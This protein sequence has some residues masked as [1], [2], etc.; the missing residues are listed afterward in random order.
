M[1]AEFRELGTEF[2]AEM[3]GIIT[4]NFGDPL[5][6]D[7]YL[8]RDGRVRMLFTQRLKKLKR[9]VLGFVT[10][11]DF[12]G[13]DT[14][15]SSNFGELFYATVPEVDS[16]KGPWLREARPTVLHEVKHLASYAEHFVREADPEVGWLEEATAMVA[17]EIY[18]RRFSHLRQGSNASYADGVACAVDSTCGGWPLVMEPNFYFL[19]EYLANAESLSP[20]SG[21]RHTYGSGWS[22]VRWATDLSPDPEAT[23]LAAITRETAAYG[24]ANLAMRLNRPFPELILDWHMATFLDDYS[25]FIPAAPEFSMRSWN[26]RDVY[27]GLS[28]HVRGYRQKFPLQTNFKYFGDF[29]VRRAGLHSAGASFTKIGGPQAATQLLALTQYDGS[30]LPDDTALRFAVARIR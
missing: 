12:Y 24:S 2:E 20:I 18:A 16:M 25:G 10:A 9:G 15:P 22:L 11:C 3:W 27:L 14:Y 17:E 28:Q 29:Q 4:R 23:F 7:P 19:Y 1:D 6:M 30:G 13:T 8:D 21:E 26:T 5:A